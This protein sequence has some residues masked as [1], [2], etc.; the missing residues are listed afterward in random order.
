MNSA[1]PSLRPRILCVDDEQAVLDGLSLHLRR[2]YDVV[3]ATSGLQGLE[4]LQRDA[5]IAVVMSDMRM[6]G[7]DGSAFLGRARQVVPNA[8]RMLLT[9]QSDLNSAIAAVNEGGIFRFLAKP[10][11]PPTILAAVEAAMEQNR[12]VT[13][14]RVL[15]EQT[16]HGSIKVL[17]DILSLTNPV[18]FGRA[19]RI[20]QLVTELAEKLD[21]RDKW[22]LEVA[23]MLSQLGT[24]T[25]PA[26]TVEKLYYNRPLTPEEQKMVARAPVLTEQLVRNIPRLETVAEILAAY[27]KPLKRADAAPDDPHKTQ[28]DLCAQLLRT[29]LDFDSLDSQGN[30]AA[31]AIDTMRSRLDRYEG[32]VLDALA[33]LRGAQGPRLGIRE[34]YLSVLCVGMVFVDDVKTTN[35]MLLVARGFEITPGFLERTR[36]MKPGTVK[37]PLRVVMR[38]ASRMGIVV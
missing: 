24:I 25:L 33:D 26:E 2:R 4:V 13:A 7:M 30:S 32:R 10:C 19:T 9:G 14:E 27:V 38:P 16:L 5:T 6:P 15:L 28:V 18:S 20:K 3:T 29:A 17:T 1:T 23:A 12:L 35:G 11:P 31:L 34:V 37:E 22:Q 36:N 21:V 8:V